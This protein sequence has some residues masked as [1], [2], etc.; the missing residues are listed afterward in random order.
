HVHQDQVRALRAC[1]RHCS[2]SVG[3]RDHTIPLEGQPPPDHIADECLVFYHQN[4]RHGSS[5]RISAHS[6]RSWVSVSRSA[7]VRE[8]LAP[9][10]TLPDRGAQLLSQCNYPSIPL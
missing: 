4:R 6:W 8:F 3:R 10:Q 1:Q 5:S 7:F 2:S 9:W